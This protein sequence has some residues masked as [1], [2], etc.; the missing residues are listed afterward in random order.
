MGLLVVGNTNGVTG[1][2]G[3]ADELSIGLPDG[4]SVEVSV[5]LLV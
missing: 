4:T 5:G 3:D 1:G 2:L